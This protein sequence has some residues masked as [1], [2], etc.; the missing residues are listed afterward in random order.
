MREAK[1]MGQI[2]FRYR[3]RA[4]LKSLENPLFLSKRFPSLYWKIYKLSWKDYLWIFENPISKA[5]PVA[6]AAGYLVYLNDILV[7]EMGFEFISANNSSVIGLDFRMKLMLVYFGLVLL[8]IARLIYLARRPHSIS[9]GPDLSSWVDYG[10]HNFTFTDFLSFH[11]DI[12]VNQHRTLYGKYYTDDWEAFVDDASWSKSGRTDGMDTVGKRASREH[13]SYGDAKR[14]HEDLLR[15]ILIDRYEEFSA[16]NKI[17][18]VFAVILALAGMAMF[19]LPNL[20]L[21]LVLLLSVIR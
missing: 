8:A 17:S 12:Q 20:D 18:L 15:S 10:M 7:R 11:D 5:S 16:R 3:V 19:L 1:V 4:A 6:S 14:R 9:H 13:V 21:F 2:P